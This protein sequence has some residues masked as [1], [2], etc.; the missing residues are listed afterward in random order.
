M[1]KKRLLV[2][3]DSPTA[4]TGF[5]TVT[6]NVLANIP[7]SWDIY[8]LAIN[9][10]GDPHPLQG[11][12]TLYPPINGGDVYGFG[13]LAEMLQ[14][15]KP[16]VIWILNDPWLVSEYVLRIRKMGYHGPLVVYTPVDSLGLKPEYVLPLNNA[17]HVVTYTDWA[18]QELRKAGLTTQASVIPHGVDLTHFQPVDKMVARKELFKD[19]PFDYE[20][21]FIV[22]YTAR[23]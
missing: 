14:R 10:Q 3:A 2:I 16:D 7:K 18:L 5:S 11:E 12:Y 23:N 22:N 13:R 20:N 4:A 9:Y 1:S 17:T 15:V 8:A 19:L 21:A 6:R